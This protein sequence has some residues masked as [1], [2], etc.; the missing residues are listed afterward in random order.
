VLTLSKQAAEAIR[1]MVEDS[2]VGPNGG[3]RIT[4]SY[5]DAGETALDFD[6]AAGPAEGD[7]TV[8]SDNATVF[9]DPKA[10]ELLADKH[11][12]VH[13]HGDHV[14]FLIEEQNTVS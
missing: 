11:L 10:A 7:E 5:D 6:L 3:L 1:G 2:D 14:H 4:G 9:L 13:A 12:D 8:Q